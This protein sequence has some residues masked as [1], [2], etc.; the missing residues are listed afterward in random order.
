MSDGINRIPTQEVGEM[1]K[2][3]DTLH[4]DIGLEL[5]KQSLEMDPTERDAIA[6]RVK[7]KLDCILMPLVSLIA[8]LLNISDTCR[9][10]SFTSFHT[11]TSKP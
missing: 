9:C 8:E 5:Y 3:P 7:M 1:E 2:L 4:T 10:V 11:S 6:K